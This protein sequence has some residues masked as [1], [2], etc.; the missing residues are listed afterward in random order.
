MT[1]VIR[2]SGMIFGPFEADNCFWIENS[3]IYRKLQN[4]VKIAEFLLLQPD[5]N[6]LLVLEAK[7]SSPNPT[8][9]DSQSKFEDYIT[10]IAD[11]LLNALT[12]GVT[13]CLERHVD[14]SNEVPAGFRGLT[15]NGLKI[16]LIL[17]IKDHKRQWLSP[18]ND[19]LKKKLASTIKIWP[20][21]VIVL[22]ESLAQK[23]GLVVS[24]T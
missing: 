4:G 9:G 5:I 6:S 23:R 7:T 12:L 2:E 11:K 22:N 16:I 3:T 1:V 24:D 17:I 8:N 13:I 10:E 21:D 20:L 14:S 19:A 18:V 15:F